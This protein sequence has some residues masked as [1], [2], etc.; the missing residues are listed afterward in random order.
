MSIKVVTMNELVA[1][2]ASGEI[3][4]KTAADLALT[5]YMTGLAAYEQAKK[6]GHTHEECIRAARHELW[7]LK[8]EFTFSVK[9]WVKIL[10]RLFKAVCEDQHAYEIF[11]DE[12]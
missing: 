9:S 11:V 1:R 5:F 6:A 7:L 3:S 8:L 2:D 4:D 12:A 10:T